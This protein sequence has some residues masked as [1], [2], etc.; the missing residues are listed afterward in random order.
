MTSVLIHHDESIFPDSHEFRPER[1]IENP[2]LDR[3]LVSFSKGSRQCLGINLA[4]AEMYLCL[5]T[6]FLYFGS[7]GTDAVGKTVGVRD[8]KD[9]GVLEL[10]DTTIKDVEI[11][12][13][14][15]VPL[16]DVSSK[17]IHLRVRE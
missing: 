12:G 9:E 15:F 3:Y 1:W 5:S 7:R 2:R 8:E 6:L 10:S 16:R 4:Y 14:G 13:D 17:G 11:A